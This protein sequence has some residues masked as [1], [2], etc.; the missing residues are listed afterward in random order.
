M[1][2]LTY[3]IDFSVDTSKVDGAKIDG[4]KV[5]GAKIDIGAV[6]SNEQSGQRAKS[7]THLAEKNQFY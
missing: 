6:V 5:D 3:F 4:A 1:T 7:L 2:P